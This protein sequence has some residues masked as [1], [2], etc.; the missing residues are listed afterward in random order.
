V[1]L[2][3]LDTSLRQ[4]PL[5]RVSPE[6]TRSVLSRLHLAPTSP[7]TFRV[8]EKA[9]YLFGLSIV[10]AIMLAA[11]VVTGVVEM[12]AVDQA[13]N[14]VQE[15]LSAMGESVGSVVGSFSAWLKG[16][17]PFAY[18][19]GALSIAFFGSLILGALALVDRLLVRRFVHRV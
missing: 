4:V 10:L 19:Q 14:S 13:Q 12:G 16:Y 2:Q 7:L 3:R 18:A 8:L 6:F 11:F 17:F 5:A 9:A 15:S 1:A